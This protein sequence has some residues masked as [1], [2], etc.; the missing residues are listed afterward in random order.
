MYIVVVY[1]NYGKVIILSLKIEDLLNNLRN[2]SELT[3]NIHQKNSNIVTNPSFMKKHCVKILSLFIAAAVATGGISAI[4]RINA[5]SA[6]VSES[7]AKLKESEIINS[8]LM[9]KAKNL[10]TQNNEL[11]NKN[12][13]LENEF[14]TIIEK[15]DELENRIN[16]L[17]GVKDELYNTLDEMSSIGQKYKETILAESENT[18]P[19]KFTTLVYTPLEK[20]SSLT[21]TFASIENMINLNPSEFIAAADNV[22]TTLASNQAKF[23][24]KILEGVTIPSLWPANGRVSSEFADRTDP[25]D[26]GYEYHKGIDISVPTGSP[27]YATAGGKVITSKYSSSY[28]YYVVIDH[29]NEYKTLYAHNSELLVN[30]GDYVEAG[31]QIAL[32]GATGNVTGPH[33]H[34]EVI[35]NGVNVNP[36]DF[37][38]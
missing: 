6:A 26:G 22:T 5:L 29:G 14:N 13:S 8:Q 24:S 15:A 9:E 25:I 4:N 38:A 7:E 18:E 23:A 16:E 3:Y 37:M 34:Y 21:N 36:R 28:G 27:V 19:K 2:E 35:E 31:Q 1:E 10:E 11:E 32:S 12:T 33:V 20:T 30:V 17:N